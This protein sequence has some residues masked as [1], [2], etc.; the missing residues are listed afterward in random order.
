MGVNLGSGI[1]HWNSF[2]TV[3]VYSIQLLISY[4]DLS[5]KIKIRPSHYF[6]HVTNCYDR[7]FL[8]QITTTSGTRFQKFISAASLAS[9]HQSLNS[10]YFTPRGMIN[11]FRW[12]IE[13]Q[14]SDPDCCWFETCQVAMSYIT[15]LLTDILTGWLLFSD[16]RIIDYILRDSN[17]IL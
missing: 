8:R 2:P 3:I 15:L 7:R 10:A 6:A 9:T 12:N 14:I 4:V 1:D 11:P 5:W 16:C 17:M 13:Y